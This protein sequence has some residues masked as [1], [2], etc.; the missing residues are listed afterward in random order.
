MSANKKNATQRKAATTNNNTT[1]IT[2]TK[3]PS[4]HLS[5]NARESEGQRQ[6][7]GRERHAAS[8]PPPAAAPSPLPEPSSPVQPLF[9]LLLLPSSCILL[10]LFL[11]SS[12]LNHA[13]AH[14]RRLRLA[15]GC[16]GRPIERRG[17]DA[18][19]LETRRVLVGR[20]ELQVRPPTLRDGTACRLRHLKHQAQG[21]GGANSGDGP[22]ASAALANHRVG[23][24]RRALAERRG[25]AE[26][27]AHLDLG[28]RDHLAG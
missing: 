12:Y 3:Q 5:D 11:P 20:H 21:G 1:T 4:D 28:R 13:L 23:H 22:R 9:F 2:T 19:A 26:H 27:A 10:L 6:A 17:G 8:V 15:G 16:G 14:G 18:H 24:V 25:G 7:K